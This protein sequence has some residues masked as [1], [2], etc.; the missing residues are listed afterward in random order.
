M[1]G[2]QTQ[3]KD[4]VQGVFRA[5]FEHPSLVVTEATTVADIPAW[6][7]L[8]HISLIIALEEEFGIQF[9][10]QEVTSMTCVGDL[11]TVLEQKG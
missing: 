1:L 2:G 9:T 8:T 5:V 10:S 11:F 6:N 3:V 4:R 7:S